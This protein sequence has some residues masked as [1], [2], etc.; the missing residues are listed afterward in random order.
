MMAKQTGRPY[1]RASSDIPAIALSAHII[2]DSPFSR[3]SLGELSTLRHTFIYTSD[4]YVHMLCSLSEADW[5]SSK[6]LCT[7][8]CPKHHH[9][10]TP[11]EAG[12]FCDHYQ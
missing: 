5:I 1:H 9:G 6:A 12:A 8:T 10:L 3:P 11:S 7:K 4:H 2:S